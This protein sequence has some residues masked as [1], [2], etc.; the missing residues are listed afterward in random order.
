MEEFAKQRGHSLL[1]VCLLTLCYYCVLVPIAIEPMKGFSCTMLV[2]VAPC[3]LMHCIILILYI[4][5]E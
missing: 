3:F 2:S 5:I 4:A 1:M